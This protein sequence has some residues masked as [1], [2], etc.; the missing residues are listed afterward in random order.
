MIFKNVFLPVWNISRFVPET[1]N[2]VE[3]KLFQALFPMIDVCAEGKKK[4][5]RN[6]GIEWNVFLGEL[7]KYSRQKA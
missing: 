7:L 2:R 1:G 5:L 3:E 6:V 4:H